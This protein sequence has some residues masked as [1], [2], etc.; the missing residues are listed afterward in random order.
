VTSPLTVKGLSTPDLTVSGVIA[1]EVV[2]G[3][4]LTM[5]FNVSNVGEAPADG[6]NVSFYVDGL[7]VRTTRLGPLSPGES[8]GVEFKWV[9]DAV[10]IHSV[11]VVVDEEDV[12]AESDASNNEFVGTVEVSDTPKE[13]R[14]QTV[15]VLSVAA[16][17]AVVLWLLRRRQSSPSEASTRA[18]MCV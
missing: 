6:F 2:M 8:G 13:E 14:D 1:S 11:R 3:V 15:I 5:S 18:A 4:P 10:G 17:A 7:R 16:L 12:V 9:P